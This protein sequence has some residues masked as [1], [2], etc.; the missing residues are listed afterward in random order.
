MHILIPGKNDRHTPRTRITSFVTGLLVF[1]FAGVLQKTYMSGSQTEY[2]APIDQTIAPYA[3]KIDIAAIYSG[4]IDKNSS[5]Y[6]E[7]LS[8][9]I[10]QDIVTG[11]TSRLS[12]LFDLRRS[13]PGDSFKLFMGQGDTVLAFEYMT[14]DW[15]RYRLDREGD[16]YVATVHNI[17]LVRRVKRVEGVIE[18]SLWDALRPLLPDMETFVELTDIFGWEIDFL[19]ESQV[20]DKFSLVFEVFEKD[21]VAVKSGRIL[22][23]QYILSGVPHRAFLFQDSAGHRDYYDDRGY[24]LRKSFL[25]SP[26]NYRRISSRFSK[27]R[28]HPIHKVYRPHLGVDYAAAE[29]TPVVAASDGRIIFKG[30]QRGFG[31]YL[32]VKHLSNMVT[33]YGHLSGFARGISNGVHVV[34]GQVIGYVGCT[35]DCT[36]PHLDYRVK[37]N[38]KFVDPLKMVVPASLPVKDEFRTEFQ[39]VVDQYLPILENPVPEPLLAQLD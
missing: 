18:S 23:A 3:E 16:D 24:C 32:E 28:F 34:Q 21:S 30:W 29:G 39:L 7:L 14:N 27:H 2:D 8:S 35:G 5:L 13:K 4:T 38:G 9:S 31:N 12:R 36:G 11:I 22:A 20:G 33:C 10:S 15:K 19:T 17:D 25:K 26:L 6:N 37:K 1:I